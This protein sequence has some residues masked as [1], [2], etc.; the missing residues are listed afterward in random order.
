V[1]E[2]FTAGVDPGD[3]ARVRLQAIPGRTF[4]GKVTR[5]AYALDTKSRTLRVEIDL[6]NPDGKLHPGLYAYATIVLDEHRDALTLPA[7]AV[8]RDGTKAFCMGVREGH[9]VRL[10][11][12]VGI[13]DGTRVEIL[14]GLDGGE[15]VVKVNAASLTDGQSVELVEP[16]TPQAS[17]P[18]P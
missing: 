1:P 12:E 14:S 2:L 10:P 16:A 7:S 5:T 18:K 6:P 9:A 17:G 11:V 4:E 8:G 3:V 15:A 13:G